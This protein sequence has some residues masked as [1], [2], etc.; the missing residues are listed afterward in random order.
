ML[1]ADR[2]ELGEEIGAGGMGRVVRATDRN[3]GRQVAVKLMQRKLVADEAAVRRF[4]REMEAMLR[5][6]HP[7]IARLYDF[8]RT[9]DDELY[10]VMELIEGRSLAPALMDE[11]EFSVERVVRIGQH[12][13]RALAAVHANGIVHRDLKPENIMLRDLHGEAD[14][15]TILDFGI[16]TLEGSSRVTQTGMVAASPAYCSPEQARGGLPGPSADLYTLGVVLYELLAGRLPFEADTQLGYLYAHAHA[17]PSP[18]ERYR[19]DAPPWLRELIQELLKKNPADRPR[20]AASV[21]KRLQGGDSKRSARE[22][23]IVFPDTDLIRGAAP[24][25]ERTTMTAPRGGRKAVMWLGGLTV[26]ATGVAIALTA[27]S[28]T[29]PQSATMPA[30]VF[31]GHETQLGE[32]ETGHGQPTLDAR[33]EAVAGAAP[34][35]AEILEMDSAA[36]PSEVTD[37]NTDT[38]GTVL[39]TS[40][41]DVSSTEDGNDGSDGPTADAS[42]LPV[43][44]TRPPVVARQFTIKVR[45]EPS[46]AKVTWSGGVGHT[47]FSFTCTRQVTLSF[48]MPNRLDAKQLIPCSRDETVRVKLPEP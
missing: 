28:G 5:L 12:V 44:D 36:A 33:G 39:P 4:E 22:R 32:A 47:P 26:A 45:S 31:M 34:G 13:A 8:G 17:A 18:L 38:S 43:V 27:G 41:E 19:P 29:P 24:L 20:D 42:R 9:D 2:Y 16:A 40:T 10:L 37:D 15:V 30:G 1:I 48:T 21:L 7:N 35:P 11:E 6:E 3:T 25:A 23:P 46:G 14:W